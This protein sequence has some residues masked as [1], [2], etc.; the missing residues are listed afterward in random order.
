[1]DQTGNQ[2][3][4]YGVGYGQ[5]YGQQ[6]GAPTQQASA[7][8]QT[9]STADPDKKST[10]KKH[11]WTY[12]VVFAVVV[13]AVIALGVIL[14]MAV[15]NDDSS[16]SSSG[17]TPTPPPITNGCSLYPLPADFD[18]TDYYLTPNT[19][20]FGAQPRNN[21]GT[22]PQT[23]TIPDD[24]YDTEAFEAI[25]RP[26]GTAF[27]P[28]DAIGWIVTNNTD[29]TY[30]MYSQWYDGGTYF[31]TKYVTAGKANS[32]AGWTDGLVGDSS[33]V[34]VFYIN[35]SLFFSIT[36]PGTT[37]PVNLGSSASGDCLV[38]PT[39]SSSIKLFNVTISLDPTTQL[40]VLTPGACTTSKTS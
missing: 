3:Q 18:N 31:H 4:N 33:Q 39:F 37:A 21:G 1:M 25:F 19:Q 28:G 6:Y 38:T 8:T 30:D 36:M 16:S 32:V 20:Y 35:Q 23:C 24:L 10:S 12:I 14:L 40:P 5:G 15:N 29:A 13:L 2:P 22:G 9:N 17:S 34:P 27:A 26:N 11:T 7:P